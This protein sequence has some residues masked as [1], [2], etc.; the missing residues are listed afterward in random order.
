MDPKVVRVIEK[1]KASTLFVAKKTGEAADV[2]GKKANVVIETTKMNL[3]IFDINS[4]ID[5]LYK[6]IGKLVHDVH[7][8]E[9]IDD[10]VLQSKMELVDEK[11]FKVQEL[12]A[13]IEGMKPV[14]SVCD[15]CGCEFKAGDTFCSKCGCQL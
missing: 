3:Q 5:T 13:K 7:M 9:E 4:E 8:G 15:N 1:V 12:R 10:E 6:E 2:A 14:A 11:M